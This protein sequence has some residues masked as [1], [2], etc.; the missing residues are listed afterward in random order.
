MRLGGLLLYA[1]T[2]AA[3]VIQ[4]DAH[5][6][7]ESP[8]VYPARTRTLA[9]MTGAGDWAD[10]YGKARALIA[11]M[12]LDEKSN[13]TYGVSST[14]NGC[15]GNI[16][17][18]SRL[19]FPGLCLQDAGNGVRGTDMVNSYPAG[20]TVGASW[21]KEL[22]KLRGHYLGG[23]FRTKGVNVAL[24]PAVGPL[25]RIARGGR[26]WEVFSNDPYLCGSLAAETITGIQGQGVMVSVKHFIG[27]E[28]ETNRSPLEGSEPPVEA[29]SSNI[30]D[31]TL[32]ELYLWPFQ[33]AMKAGAANVMCSYNRVNN[34]YACANSKLLNGVLKTELGFQGFTVSDW[35]AQ[36]SGVASALA[37]LDMAMPGSVYWGANL[38]TAIQNGSVP[39]S[40]LDDMATR[41]VASW[42]YLSQNEGYP[43]P[44]I[45]IPFEIRE[46]HKRINARDPNAVPVLFQG[47]TEGHVLV[48]NLDALPL[49]G[50]QVVSV[51]G[52]SATTYQAWGPVQGMDMLKWL[53]GQTNANLTELL[54]ASRSQDLRSSAIAING[55]IFTGGG[56]GSTTPGWIYSPLD[57][58]TQRAMKDGTDL[59]WDTAS[60]APSVSESDACLVFINAW[61]TETLDRSALYD[62]YSDGLVNSVA[63]QCGNTIVVIHNAGI[64]LVDG[65]VDHPNV[66]AIIYAHLPGQSSG[67]ATIALLYGDENFSGKLPYTVARQ[68]SDYGDL[69]DPDLP[70]GNFALFPQSDFDEGTTIDYR[71]FDA[72]NITPRYEFGFG[73]SYTTFEYADLSIS[74]R[75]G[76]SRDEYPSGPIEQGGHLDLWDN[77]GDVRFRIKNTGGV[78]GQ[79]I[80]Q[81][82][83]DGT[84]S[85][86]HLRGFEKVALEP[87]QTETVTLSLTRRDL[88]E[89][90][91]V[92]QNWKLRTGRIRLWVGASSRD[93][94]LEGFLEL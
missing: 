10:A 68:P 56:S 4:S 71:A 82:Y 12:T 46:P 14:H 52:Y 26:N 50:P 83:L 15:S 7:G 39:E 32:H 55:T 90:D 49:K 23:E 31:K 47:A 20:I 18:V 42:Y 66:T 72:F 54:L 5:F 17:G 85:L 61:A 34:S 88:S 43:D 9:N 19:G 37:G 44:G 91:A 75:D 36:H 57:A 21:N 89:W 94:R 70:D 59:L 6:Y 79:E 11:E 28:Q 24:G 73:M 8:P 62:D 41:I 27:N 92:S 76:L 51:F 1:I 69:L 16:P 13:L 65:F 64:R 48:K 3:T 67:E 40:R 78:A 86:K 33:D 25:G 87:G 93:I 63:D 35:D 45:G 84:D 74:Y 38:T 22:T 29:V 53:L 77:L 60:P 2:A 30:D 80:S 81:L 58:L